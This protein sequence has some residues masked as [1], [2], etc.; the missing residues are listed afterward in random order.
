MYEYIIKMSCN[1]KSI[2]FLPKVLYITLSLLYTTYAQPKT[3]LIVITINLV[4]ALILHRI[5]H[6]EVVTFSHKSRI[7]LIELC[8]I[9]CRVAAF[10]PIPLHITIYVCIIVVYNSIHKKLYFMCE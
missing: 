2:L 9:L 6:T 3:V 4:M 8:I 7:Y 1:N 5:S 10:F